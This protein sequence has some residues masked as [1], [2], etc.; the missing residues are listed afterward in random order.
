ME[1]THTSLIARDDTLFG[2]CQGIGEDFG[3]DPVWLRVGLSVSLLWNPAFV[4]A[5]Y[6]V[7]GALVLI[8][9]LLFPNPRARTAAAQAPLAEPKVPTPAPVRVTLDDKVG[10]QLLPLAA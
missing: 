9:R 1:D 4:F 6:A 3:F 10:R 5:A 7:L 2:I 8:S